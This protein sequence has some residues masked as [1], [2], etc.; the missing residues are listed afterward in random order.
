MTQRQWAIPAQVP[1]SPWH[2][3]RLDRDAAAAIVAGMF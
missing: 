3:W 2:V 1:Q